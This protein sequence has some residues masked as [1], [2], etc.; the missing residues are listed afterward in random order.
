M[1][2]VTPLQGTFY[3]RDFNPPAI[4]G[5]VQVTVAGNGAT[6]HQGKSFNIERCLQLEYSGSWI[7]FDNQLPTLFMSCHTQELVAKKQVVTVCFPA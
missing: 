7:N 6:S 4:I 5:V 2:V 1:R 3:A